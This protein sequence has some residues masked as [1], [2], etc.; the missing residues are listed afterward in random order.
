MAAPTPTTYTEWDGSRGMTY[1]DTV[2][3]SADDLTDSVIVDVSAL[4]PA[5]S[6]VKVLG[7]YASVNGDISATVEFDATTDQLI[8]VFRNQT[9]SAL[10][11]GIDF[12]ESPNGGRV[13]SN[14]AA[15]FVGDIMVTT[16]NVA[17]GDELT[18]LIFYQK[19]T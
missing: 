9:D 1:W 5:A 19:K 10:R 14:T 8:Y 16:S 17:S 12:R 4:S 13:P 15:G 3:S 2:W 7:I 18:L 6:S 11:D